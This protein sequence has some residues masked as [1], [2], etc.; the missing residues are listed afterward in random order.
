MYSIGVILGGN[1]SFIRLIEPYSISNTEDYNGKYSAGLNL[2]FGIQ[3]K[4]Y[5]NENIEINLDGIY[6]TKRFSYKIIQNDIITT[7]DEDHSTLSIPLTGTYDFNLG[8][9]SPY[10]RVGANLD[11]LLKA[12]ATF[13]KKDEGLKDSDV[14]IKDERNDYNISAVI[15]GGLK[16]NIKMGYLML[17]VRY[18]FGFLNIVNPETRYSQD[19]K[20]DNYGYVDDD[21]T[22]NNLFISVGYVYPFYKIK[23]RK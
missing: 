16:F 20:W 8:T 11:Y 5:I 12:T 21:F 18:Q 15:G 17:D 7:Y 9:W 3:I 6:T 2:Q 14:K 1:Y 4:R 13:E 10:L 23:E 19:Y 22:M